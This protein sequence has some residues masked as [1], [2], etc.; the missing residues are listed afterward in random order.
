MSINQN[1]AKVVATCTQ[2][3]AALAKYVRTKTAMTVDGKPYKLSDVTDIYQTCVDTRSALHVKRAEYDKAL[4][5]RDSA[6]VERQAFDK[7]FKAWVMSQ[8]GADSQEA[9]EFGFAPAKVGVK[10]TETKLNA[11]KQSLATREARGTRGKR[12]KEKIKGTVRF[13]AVPAAPATIATAAPPAA[14]APA[15]P[16]GSQSLAPSANGVPASH[17]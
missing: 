7:G 17:S 13:P 4:D 14:S 15:S 2:R 5:A 16:N 11:V 9:L 6:E 1:N 12:Q 10:T 3:L 8:F